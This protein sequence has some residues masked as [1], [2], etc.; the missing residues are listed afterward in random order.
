MQVFSND[1][2]V[3]P[4]AIGRIGEVINLTGNS[5]RLQGRIKPQNL[6]H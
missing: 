1:Y 6:A 2:S 5:Y 3:D 4:S